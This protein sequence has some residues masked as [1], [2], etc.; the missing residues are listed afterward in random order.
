MFGVDFILQDKV[1]MKRPQ[2]L[3]PKLYYND[4]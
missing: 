2:H 1:V 3:V 4:E